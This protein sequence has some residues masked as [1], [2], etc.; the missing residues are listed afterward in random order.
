[1]G[2]LARSFAG[3]DKK[4]PAECLQRGLVSCDEC[5]EMSSV[6]M[7]PG[8]PAGAGMMMVPVD[9]LRAEHCS[10]AYRSP[11]GAVKLEGVDAFELST[12]LSL[13]P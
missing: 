5:V 9:V 2:S 3:A 11:S 1:M 7:Q 12:R 8:R 10:Q 4:S 13:T 6:H